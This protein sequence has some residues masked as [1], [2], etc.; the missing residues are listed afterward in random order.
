MCSG[1]LLTI[2]RARTILKYSI[3][4]LAVGAAILAA[5]AL[6]A[7]NSPAQAA[8][9]KQSTAAFFQTAGQWLLNLSMRVVG[10]GNPAAVM[11]SAAFCVGLAVVMLGV[12]GYLKGM[13][14]KFIH[15]VYP[16]PRNVKQPHD[17]AQ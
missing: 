14:N 7:S 16:P 11:A 4:G 6:S 10:S 15:G 5:V 3:G 2:Q 12:R 13:E 9:A 8:A 17:E 1:T